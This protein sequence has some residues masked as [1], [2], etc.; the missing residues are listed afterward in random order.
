MLTTDVV[1]IGGGIMGTATAYHLARRGVQV[2]LLEKSHLGAGSTGLTGGIIRQHYS[3][4]TTARM[5]QRALRVWEDFDQAVGGDAGFVKTGVVFL[6]GPEGANSMAASIS[7]QQAIG[8]RTTLLDGPAL[9]E[10][11]PYLNTSDIGAAAY[12]PDGGYADG[13]LACLAYA[14]RARDLGAVVRQGTAVTGIRLSGGKVAGVD[15]SAGP[16][17]APVVVNTAGPWGPMLVRASGRW[18]PGGAEPAPDRHL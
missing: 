7:M 9:H 5:A 1:V 15:T 17:D 6:T 10:I 4:E 16:V 12:E 11:A 8:I 13:N 3:I 2:T 18:D 14:A